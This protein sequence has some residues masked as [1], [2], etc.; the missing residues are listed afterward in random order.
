[1]V[2]NED[3]DEETFLEHKDRL[4][5]GVKPSVI[6]TEEEELQMTKIEKMAKIGRM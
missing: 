5:F 4:R 6:F 2:Q 3:L 1:M